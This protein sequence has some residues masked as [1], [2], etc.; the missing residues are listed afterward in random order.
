MRGDRIQRR[1]KQ[2]RAEGRE[3]IKKRSWKR[4]EK[5]EEREKRRVKT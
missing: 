1:G 4:E 3:K 5:G 2:R